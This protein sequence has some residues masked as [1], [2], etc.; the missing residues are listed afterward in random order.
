MNISN[1]WRFYLCTYHCIDL[2]LNSS[3]VTVY[4]NRYDPQ[5]TQFLS[6][7]KLSDFLACLEEPFCIPRPNIVAIVAFNLPIARGNKIHCL[8]VLYALVRH[9]LGGEVDTESEVFK[10]VGCRFATDKILMTA[11]AKQYSN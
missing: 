1:F 10:K 2:I 5:A 9:V 8:D 7:S 6:F 3:N 4:S 11:S